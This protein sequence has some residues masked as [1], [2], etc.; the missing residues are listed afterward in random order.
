M[1]TVF[2]L[3]SRVFY[4]LWAPSYIKLEECTSGANYELKNYQLLVAL[5]ACLIVHKCRLPAPKTYYTENRNCL[6]GMD[7][8]I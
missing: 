6:V 5:N 7:I 8:D 3:T 4:P 2:L 1:A